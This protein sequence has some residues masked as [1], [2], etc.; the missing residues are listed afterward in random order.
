MEIIVTDFAKAELK[1]IY[2]FYQTNV[3]KQIADKIKANIILAIKSLLPNPYI[4]QT[5]EYLTDL[6]LDHRRIITGNYK[7]IYRVENE[8]IYITDIFDCRR[9]P[10]DIHS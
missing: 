2:S 7:I 9:N 3:S 5:E 8:H 10:N 6:N 4:R 1:N